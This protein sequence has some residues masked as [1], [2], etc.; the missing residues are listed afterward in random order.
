MLVAVI[1]RMAKVRPTRCPKARSVSGIETLKAG[2][3]R[4]WNRGGMERAEE[5]VRE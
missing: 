3:S 4:Y 2:A 1:V 5:R